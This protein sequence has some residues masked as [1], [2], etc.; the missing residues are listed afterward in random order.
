MV[1]RSRPRFD[2]LQRMGNTG[3]WIAFV[4]ILAI[5]GAGLILT[6]DH[7][8]NDAD[9]P[10]LTARGDTIVAPRLAALEPAVAQLSS[11][12]NAIAQ[13]S[14]TLY[15]HLRARDTDAVRADTTAGDQL[16]A[17]FAA[18]LA[19][20]EAGRADLV[21]GTTMSAISEANRTEVQAINAAATAAEQLNA[22]WTGITGAAS[23]TDVVIDA[24][25]Q[26]DSAVLNATAQARNADYSGALNGLAMAKT[27]L[28]RATTVADDADT[29]G[30]DTSTLRGLI[31]RNNSYDAALTALYTILDG[32]GGVM[33][34][35]AQQ[36][37]DVVQQAQ[38]ALPDNG[39]ALTV[40]VSDIGG[41]QVT[42]GMIALD[43]LRGTIA[44]AVPEPAA[45][46]SPG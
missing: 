38:A 30:L 7:A 15:G 44:E 26:H 6:F 31:D 14:R 29:I 20:V 1:T 35:D 16:V 19:P 45:S 10:E 4:V 18:D 46:A 34:P 22:A 27:A 25:A 36:A 33:T 9:R 8:Q 12:A 39:T 43:Q 37:F 42:L 32:N 24:L 5:C 28:D 2:R 40:I 41:Q 13:Q 17:Q 23:L 21:D 11:D 3:V